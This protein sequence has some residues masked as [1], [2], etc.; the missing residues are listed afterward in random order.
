MAKA[1]GMREQTGVLTKR[2]IKAQGKREAA[3]IIK[4]VRS[5]SAVKTMNEHFKKLQLYDEN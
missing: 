4:R 3:R 2:T 5:L 1:I